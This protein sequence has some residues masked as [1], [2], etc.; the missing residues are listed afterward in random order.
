MM[1]IEGLTKTYEN[2][3]RALDGV[4]LEVRCGTFGLLG[5]NGAGKSSL[6]RTIA[7]LQE[8]DAGS[9]R[10][11]GVDVLRE[12][13]TVR[14]FLGYLPQDFGVYPRVAADTMLDHLAVLK[15]ITA[16][17]ERRDAV[18]ALLKM[19]N[20]WDV[21]KR[22][23]G[24]YSGGMRQRFGIAQALLG[25]PRLLILDEPTVGLDPDER[26]RFLNLLAEL[27]E[28]IVVLLSTHIVADVLETCGEVAILDGGR[29]RASGAPQTLVARLAGTVW[30]KVVDRV[31]VADHESR[32]Q[33]VSTRLRAGRTVLRVRSP[34]SPGAG[35]E[36]AEPDL[37][38]VYFVALASD[39]AG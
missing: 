9:I 20:L 1:T 31:D 23:L 18:D 32:M 37:E 5:R 6:M 16:K 35:F 12:K 11:D 15:G 3:V 19:T 28:S 7:T 22:H 36:P 8:C 27:G 29:V 13:D 25:E 24:T 38:D 17:G 30:Q 4:S 2:G 34:S 39:S 14:R 10:F 33:V 21:R 26:R